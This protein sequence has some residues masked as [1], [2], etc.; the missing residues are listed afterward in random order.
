MSPGIFI[1]QGRGGGVWV[2]GTRCGTVRAAL[3]TLVGVLVATAAFAETDWRDDFER[4]L[5]ALEGRA[6][7]VMLHLEGQGPRAFAPYVYYPPLSAIWAIDAE[8]LADSGVSTVRRTGTVWR[9]DAAGH[10]GVEVRWQDGD[11]GHLAVGAR[12]PTLVANPGRHILAGL[13]DAIL[14]LPLAASVAG[15]PAGSRFQPNGTVLLPHGTPGAAS[16]VQHG[17]TLSIEHSDG[18]VVVE[19]AEIVF[20]ALPGVAP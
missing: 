11:V 4:E 8:T 15:L 1:S 7:T 9:V 13:Y 6:F 19:R 2:P 20:R 18:R 5:E 12:E 3:L 16:W 17:S 10:E 14:T